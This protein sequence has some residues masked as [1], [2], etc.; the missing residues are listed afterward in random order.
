MQKISK[1]TE[2]IKL[3]FDS[4]EKNP[5]LRAMGK[6]C[7]NSLWGKMAQR[8]NMCKTEI[9]SEPKRLFQLLTSAALEVKS[10]LPVNEDV[11][12]VSQANNQ[13]TAC[14][15]QTTNVVVAA[16]VTCQGRLTLY[17]YLSK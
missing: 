12:Y 17:S 5:G 9:V 2:G 15:S 4:I 1:K 11:M 13:D 8:D 7:A 10:V 14:I 6:L 16:Y 3:D